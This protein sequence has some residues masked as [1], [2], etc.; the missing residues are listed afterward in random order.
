MTLNMTMNEP[1]TDAVLEA[2]KRDPFLQGFKRGFE[3]GFYGA[4][5]P[6]T[7]IS[8]NVEIKVINSPQMRSRHSAI[9][10]K[11]VNAKKRSA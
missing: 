11:I 7:P 1:H 10:I 9:R 6:M 4:F 5:A 3:E 2:E 8:E